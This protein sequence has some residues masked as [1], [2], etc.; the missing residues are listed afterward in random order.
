MT[1]L[2]AI[3]F[4]N[5]HRQKKTRLCNRPSHNTSWTHELSVQVDESRRC[6]TCAVANFL[7]TVHMTT[8]VWNIQV[9]PV[10]KTTESWNFQV[11]PVHK[12][13]KMRK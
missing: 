4:D 12:F 10:H 6:A 2:V 1:F 8:E 13:Y 7:V 5:K 3:L 9:V 11:A